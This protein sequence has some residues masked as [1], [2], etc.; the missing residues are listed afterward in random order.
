MLTVSERKA[1]RDDLRA[2]YAAN[3]GFA[4]A[5]RVVAF[6][7]DSEAMEARLKQIE[8]ALNNALKR[9]AIKT[10]GEKHERTGKNK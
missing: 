6:C 8:T 3:K 10:K 5:E 4:F 1:I 9:W 2:R 7:D